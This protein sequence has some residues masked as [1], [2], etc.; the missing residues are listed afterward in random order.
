MHKKK[1]FLD[2]IPVKNPKFNWFTKKEDQVILTMP[3]TGFFHWIA[4]NWFHRPKESQ[5]HFDELGS[6][7]WQQI[8]GIKNIGQIAQSV[9]ETF[10]EQA[11]PLLNRLTAFFRILNRHLFIS[12]R[13]EK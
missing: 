10:G 12:F 9:K 1:N 11:E 13:K 7:V 5:I 3:H 2:M 8:D 4:Q 6:F